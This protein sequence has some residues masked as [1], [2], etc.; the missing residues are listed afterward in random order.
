MNTVG[1]S[2]FGAACGTFP[3]QFN[4]MTKGT[5]CRGSREREY[6]RVLVGSGVS[7]ETG[8]HFLFR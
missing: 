5:S 4:V 6:D 8:L 1:R 7:E 2:A 3:A